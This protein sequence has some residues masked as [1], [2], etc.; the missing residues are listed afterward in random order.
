MY[1]SFCEA[2]VQILDICDAS[3][4][5]YLQ[6]A[7]SGIEVTQAV[8]DSRLSAPV[9]PPRI[10]CSASIL[11][12]KDP[13]PSPPGGHLSGSNYYSDRMVWDFFGQ[14]SY[15]PSSAVPSLLRTDYHQDA[16]TSTDG[17][18]VPCTSS[19]SNA[20]T[21]EMW[22]NGSIDQ[23]TQT[24]ADRFDR[25]ADRCLTAPAYSNIP[26][27]DT[28]LLFQSGIDNAARSHSLTDSDSR[29]TDV[30]GDGFP[31]VTSFGSATQGDV[32]SPRSDDAQ[33]VG[34]WKRFDNK[35]WHMEQ[36]KLKQKSLDLPAETDTNED[37]LPDLSSSN[38]LSV[39]A[40]RL[41][42]SIYGGQSASSTHHATPA[43]SLSSVWMREQNQYAAHTTDQP[44]SSVAVRKA[45]CGP[46]P[47]MHKAIE[48]ERHTEDSDVYCHNMYG[49]EFGNLQSSFLPHIQL[50]Q[51]MSAAE[52]S[53]LTEEKYNYA[54]KAVGGVTE[55][56]NH[57]D[58]V[59]ARLAAE[60]SRQLGLSERE[61]YNTYVDNCRWQ[62]FPTPATHVPHSDVL[63]TAAEDAILARR[64]SIKELKSRFEAETS[65]DAS[66]RE[67]AELPS[68]AAAAAAACRRQF[69]S[70]SL[71]AGC[72]GFPGRTRS[73][74]DETSRR[75][76][77]F[78]T[79][80]TN[81]AS[82][83]P[84]IANSSKSSAPKG[85]FVTRSSIA[86][87][88]V[89]NLPVLPTDADIEHAERRQFER[90][91]DRRKV[92]EAADTQPVA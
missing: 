54:S 49:S 50:P 65:G 40:L 20:V 24:D 3:G 45:E 73:E 8:D 36:E 67:A 90:L 74:S 13:P 63:Q 89:V 31:S 37:Q 25:L 23:Y 2:Y 16:A 60:T 79:K 59:G 53:S 15:P 17:N 29:V 21:W 81:V 77:S 44:A 92:F 56:R 82:A 27:A 68:A 7:T 58:D 18:F 42:D 33:N 78:D 26:V 5:A 38:R 9:L 6:A 57:A 84:Y 41:Y 55:T 12:W 69:E 48:A 4:S 52:Q 71:K 87:N 39:A 14:Q 75:N 64:P 10:P 66:V 30:N 88:A 22:R 19:S 28:N 51:Q 46:C 85:R 1:T 70:S 35:M 11:H 62:S 47:A 72:R 91:V 61:A 32:V 43:R 83:S 76:L 80:R 34:L 86:A